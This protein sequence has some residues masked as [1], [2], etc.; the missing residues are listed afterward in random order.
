MKKAIIR[1]IMKVFAVGGTALLLAASAGAFGYMAVWLFAHIPNSGGYKAVGGFMVA[2]LAAAA[3]L[4][5]VYMCGA[6]IVRSNKFYKGK[7]ER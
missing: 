6:W 4:A 1:D 2:L 3:A 7:F 5:V